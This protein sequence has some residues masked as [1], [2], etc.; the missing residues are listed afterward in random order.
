MRLILDPGDV[1]P[2]FSDVQPTAL[3]FSHFKINVQQAIREVGEAM[4]IE[5]SPNGQNEYHVLVHAPTLGEVM[6]RILL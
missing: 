5:T 3:E 6:R 2:M 4:Y 1:Q